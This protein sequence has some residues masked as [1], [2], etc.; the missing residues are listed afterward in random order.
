MVQLRDVVEGHIEI[1]EVFEAQRDSFYNDLDQIARYSPDREG[2]PVWEEILDY[3]GALRVE[4][5]RVLDLVFDGKRDEARL[6]LNERVESELAD[7]LADRLHRARA[8]LE[9]ERYEKVSEL[10]RSSVILMMQV[11]VVFALAGGLIVVGILLTRRWLIVPIN[12]LREATVRFSEGALD[13]R[14]ELPRGDE[15]GQL[16]EALNE[17]AGSLSIA[18]GEVLRSEAK[19]RALFENLRDAVVICDADGRV[20]EYN[21]GDTDL[22]GDT[23]LSGD[24]G[25]SRVGRLLLD[26]WPGWREAEVDWVAS[27]A[28][29]LDSGKRLRIVDLEL[30]TE[31]SIIG[32]DV[33]SSEKKEAVVD[34]VVYRVSYDTEYYAAIVFRDVTT[35]LHM[36]KRLRRAETMEVA[37]TLAGGLAHDFNNLLTSAIGSM[38][39]LSEDLRSAKQHDLIQTA[40]RACWQAASLSRRLLDFAMGGQGKPQVLKLNEAVEHVLQSLDESV[41]SG[42]SVQTEYDGDVQVKVDRDQLVQIILNLVRNACDAMSDG[43]VLTIRTDLVDASNPDE[44]GPLQPYAILT[45]EDTGHGMSAKVKERVFQPF[46]TTKTRALHRGRGLGLSTV[47][48]SAKTAGGFILLDSQE[49]VGTT[50]RVHLPVGAGSVEHIQTPTYTPPTEQGEGTIL[51]VDDEPMII[52]TCT[53]ALRKWGYTVLVADSISAAAREFDDAQDTIDLALIDINLPDGSGTILAQDLVALNPRI[54]IVFATGYAEADIPEEIASNVFGMLSKPFGL[55]ELADI[56]S[57][58]LATHVSES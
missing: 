22:L 20:V 26:A 30:V 6:L 4:T 24:A 11:V 41:F 3:R 32:S 14:I 45:V 55:D 43:G 16:G 50:F 44:K 17:M 53:A 47:Y 12:R 38:S 21:D 19:Y 46:F 13:H 54:R 10:D 15:L 29:V 23:D 28:Q 37:G 40:S 31:A 27:I 35:R 5:Q 56:L 18:Q 36:Q 51:L 52:K 8:I 7:G 2:D 58:A 9:N 1:T 39:L 48:A 25:G 49:G 33:Q 34:L 57:A 42:I